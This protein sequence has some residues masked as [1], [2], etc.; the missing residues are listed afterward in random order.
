MEG[1]ETEVANTIISPVSIWESEI[2]QGR[3]VY[4]GAS[5][6]AW[7]YTKVIVQPPNNNIGTGNFITAFVKDSIGGN[8]GKV[9]FNAS[10]S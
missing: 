10:N 2:P 1:R 3:H 8:I 5:G 6:T 4:F 7:K 9:I